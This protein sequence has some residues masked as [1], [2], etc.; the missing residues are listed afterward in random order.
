MSCLPCSGSSGKEAKGTGALSPSP[1]PSAKAA[2]GKVKFVYWAA[3][4]PDFG[5]HSGSFHLLVRP[6][7]VLLSQR[8]TFPMI[9]PMIRHGTCSLV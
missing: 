9:D 1:R 8:R 6:L 3:R 7:L 4:L 2:P 5:G